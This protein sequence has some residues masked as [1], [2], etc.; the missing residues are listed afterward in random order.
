MKKLLLIL[1]VILVSLF[2]SSCSSKNVN[3]DTDYHSKF[4]T[5]DGDDIS[6]ILFSRT[7]DEN[8]YYGNPQVKLGQDSVK[9]FLIVPVDYI[10]GFELVGVSGETYLTLDM[11]DIF[12]VGSCG[13]TCG[14]INYNGYEFRLNE[15]FILKTNSAYPDEDNSN[16]KVRDIS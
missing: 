8:A 3:I 12:V 9:M 10:V 1:F 11:G 4:K 13:E 2:V 6:Y 14:E 7:D 15:D 5:I 16:F